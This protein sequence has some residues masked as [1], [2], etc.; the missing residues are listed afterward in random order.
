M[1]R[2]CPVF[3]KPRKNKPSLWQMFFGK[4]RSWLDGLYERSYRMKMGEVRLP[5]SAIYMINEPPLVRKVLIE[6]ANKFPKHTLLGKMLQPL[7]GESIFTTNGEQWQRQRSMMDASFAQTRLKLVFPLMKAAAAAMQERLDK[8][9]DGAEYDIDIEMTH[10]T[11]DI[12]FRTILSQTLEGETGHKI[13]EAFTRFQAM[14]PRILNPVLFRMP[15]LLYPWL[16]IRRSNRAA[17]EIRSHLEVF[18]RPRYDAHR[19]G[20]P[21]NDQDILASLLDAVDPVAGTPFTFDELVDQVAMLFLAGH[22]T[23]ASALSWSLYLISNRTDIQER[24]HAETMEVMGD[25]EPDYSD[26]KRMELTWNVFRETL[27]L[28]PPVGFFAREAAEV[29]DMR[30]K[31]M[32]AGSSVVIAPWLIHRHHDLWERPDEFDPDRYTS[33]SARESLK[34]AYLPFSLG[35]RVC[36][37]ATFALQEA[38]LILATL[39]K[40]YRFEAPA[41]YQPDIVGRLTIRSENGIRVIIHKRTQEAKSFPHPLSPEALNISD[42]SV[43]SRCPMHAHT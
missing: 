28:Y 36:M 15:R 32:Q 14:T 35:P 18:I 38:G 7:L 20:T 34:C 3:P 29:Q 24:M 31:T 42:A 1:S 30:K 37:G 21:G 17:R 5:G 41:G 40:R 19:A 23:S 39:V 25:K 12:I 26:I 10:V 16:A 43:Q 11:A 6:D 22:E 9:P 8:L 13:F 4:R 33:D 2:F 27:R